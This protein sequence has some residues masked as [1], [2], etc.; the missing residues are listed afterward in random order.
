LISRDPQNYGI[1]CTFGV[2]FLAVLLTATEYNTSSAFDTAVT[3]FKQG[4]RCTEAIV[5]TV[6]EE[7]SGK[8]AITMRSAGRTAD[9]VA[10]EK[11][12]NNDEFTWQHIQYV[13]PVSDSERR[14]L[15][16]VSGYVAPGRLT[17][18]MGESGAGKAR[19]ILVLR[20]L[21]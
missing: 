9:N 14:L 4:T 10:P 21:R 5:T 11:L 12:A 6:D 17:A 2:G 16:D 7:K 13:V 3:L 8:S 1:I 15:D 18:L 20:S 19:C